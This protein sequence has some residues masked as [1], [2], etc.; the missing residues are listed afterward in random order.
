[1]SPS[2]RPL[3]QRE[4]HPPPQGGGL[5]ARSDRAVTS[6]KTLPY[7]SSPHQII[8]IT[9]VFFFWPASQVDL[10]SILREDPF[11]L[12]SAFIGLGN[13]RRVLADPSYINSMQ[14]TVIFFCATALIRP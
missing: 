8:A 2:P 10:P 11:G 13:F 9:I 4:G 1:M 12:R 14:V 7:R 5:R 3:A 6:E